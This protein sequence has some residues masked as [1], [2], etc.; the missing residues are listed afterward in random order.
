ERMLGR[1]LK[2]MLE[3]VR[4]GGRKPA[5]DKLLIATQYA[6]QLA[7]GMRKGSWVDWVFEMHDACE[8][9]IDPDVIDRLHELVRQ[10]RYPGGPALRSYM[11]NLRA[12][13]ATLSIAQQFQVRRLEGIERVVGA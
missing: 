10:I 9:L 2:Q 5:P 8:A 11:K 12:R 7:S 6:L 13:Q 3:E 1:R 4:A